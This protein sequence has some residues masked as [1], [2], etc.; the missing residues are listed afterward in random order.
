MADLMRFDAML[1]FDA[2]IDSVHTRTSMLFTYLA[3]KR[4]PGDPDN[5]FDTPTACEASPLPGRGGAMERGQ[6]KFAPRNLFSLLFLFCVQ[7]QDS[8]G[9]W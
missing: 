3:L 5:R 9:L 4:L 8:P 1:L 7:V 2:T 6:W